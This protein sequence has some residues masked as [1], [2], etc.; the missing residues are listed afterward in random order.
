MIR[1]SPSHH[2]TELSRTVPF[3]IIPQITAFRPP[4]PLKS[5]AGQNSGRTLPI[6]PLENSPLPISPTHR[7][8]PGDNEGPG[9]MLLQMIP[10]SASQLRTTT[11]GF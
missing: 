7:K 11:E 3:Q 6:R 2:S 5:T 1:E 8:V 10:L 4:T 9:V